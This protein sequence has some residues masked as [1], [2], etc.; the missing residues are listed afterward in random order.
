MD[1]GADALLTPP[2]RPEDV[3]A[4][5]RTL[6]EVSAARRTR[7][8]ARDGDVVPRASLNA[9]EAALAEE[10]RRGAEA[11]RNSPFPTL[12]HAEDGAI[13][14]TSDALHEVT[15]WTREDV[16]DMARWLACVA[17]PAHDAVVAE[18]A[19]FY[20]DGTPRAHGTYGLRCKDGSVR[21]WDVTTLALGPGPDGRRVAITAGYD[22]TERERA[23]DALHRSEALYREIFEHHPHPMWVFDRET[24]DFLAVNDAAVRRYGFTREEFLRMKTHDIRP[25]E[26]VARMVATVRTRS[27]GVVGSGPWRHVGRDGEAFDVEVTAHDVDFEGRPAA[28]VL[29]FDV[30]ER[31]RAERA[32]ER[33]NRLYE[34]LSQTDE[35]IVRAKD[36]VTLL[37]DVCRLAVEHG[38]FRVAWVGLRG[39][40]G[41]VRPV[42]RAG[43][44]AAVVDEVLEAIA[45]S[46]GPL[47]P[48][49]PVVRNDF[50]AD[51]TVAPWHAKAARAG[52]A[53]V[54][55]FPLRQGGRVVGALHLH[56]REVGY[57]RGAE[58]ATLEQMAADVSFA[59]DT[60]DRAQALE[61]AAEVIGSSPVVLFRAGPEEGWPLDFASENVTRWGWDAA[62][63]V[64]ART[65]FLSLVA[66]D[67]RASVLDGVRA[68]LAAGREDFLLT[69]RLRAADGALRWVEDRTAVVRDGR[70][71][72]SAFRCIVTDVT[73]R[74]EA[75]TTSRRQLE[76]LRRWQHLTLGREDRV[77]ELKREVNELALRLGEPAR[78]ASQ[79]PAGAT[80]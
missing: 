32:L 77:Q 64:R 52:I 11:I 27:G 69:Y 67:D 68:A 47:L 73:E 10:R 70:G 26:D 60:L 36:R 13:L 19:A 54:A 59:F 4:L 28:L 74:H 21:T 44:A 66:D 6:A 38:G 56:A 9:T 72:V 57:F 62:A 20:R 42:S 16:P 34:L 18:V 63:I 12:L 55:H 79:A 76:E 17:G 71:E 22:V 14:A 30:T 48:E 75:E 29:A 33:L 61:A 39:D 43:A 80:P 58:L 46:D 7:A 35:L 5:L 15:G 51:P 23:R 37:D 78:Y 41:V 25:P 50:C 3:A 49:A 2:A 45:S 24:F 53:A 65:P 40:D 31:L 1:A 8:G